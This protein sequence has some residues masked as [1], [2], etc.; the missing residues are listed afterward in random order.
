MCILCA[1]CPTQSS[2]NAYESKGGREGGKKGSREEG[3]DSTLNEG[4]N[5]SPI[6]YGWKILE[7][8]SSSL[9]LAL[10]K[11]QWSVNL[12]SIREGECPILATN[13]VKTFPTI[14]MSTST[15]MA[16]FHDHL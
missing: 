4:A 5:T 1:Q 9:P 10:N 13:H 6:S 15:G 12:N 3:N 8:L 14:Q 2:L 16:L 11:I 7:S